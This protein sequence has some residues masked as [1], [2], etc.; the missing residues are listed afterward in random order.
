MCSTYLPRDDISSA[1]G[2]V[3]LELRVLISLEE[4]ESTG[5]GKKEGG[6]EGGGKQSHY[7]SLYKEPGNS[8]LKALER[9]G[10][11]TGQ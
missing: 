10:V 5:N 8:P 11:I 6:R 4:R 9:G 1:V 3:F 7:C 2:T